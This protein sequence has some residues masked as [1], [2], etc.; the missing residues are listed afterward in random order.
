MA[1]VL[2]ASCLR[3]PRLAQ[4]VSARVM[5]VGVLCILTSLFASEGFA[6]NDPP[7]SPESL[8]L[9]AGDG[10]ISLSWNAPH[11]PGSHTITR[12]E[13]SYVSNAGNQTY[14]STGG[15]DLSY[16]I[17]GL[18]NGYV[19][20]VRVRAVSAAGNGASTTGVT[21]T[22]TI[23]APT[24]LT[25]TAGDGQISLSWTAP[26]VTT[27]VDYQY[28]TSYP[29]GP[30]ASPTRT[31][32]KNTTLTLTGLTNGTT[33]T[34]N[35]RAYGAGGNGRSATVTATP[36]IAAPTGLTATTG[37]T[38]I[39]LN[40]TAVSGVSTITKYQYQKDTDAWADTSANTSHI[41]TGLTNG[42]QYGFK[43]RAVGTGGGGTATASVTG[44]PRLSAPAAPTGL[45]A[46]PG[47]GQITLNWTAPSGPITRY[48]YSQDGGTWTS[49]GGT[50]TTYIVTNLTNGT[51][52]AFRVR[53]V[54]SAGNGAASASVTGTPV[55]TV[56]A[57]G[58]PTGLTAT[59]GNGQITLNWTAPSGPITRYEYTQDDGTT[60]TSTGGTSTTYI[61][62]NLTNG[63]QYTFKVR[64]VNSAGNGA[65]SASVTA[66]P[67]FSA[68]PPPPPPPPA[69]P[70]SL[71]VEMV[72]NADQKTANA[73][74]TW[75]P[76]SD[77]EAEG[78]EYRY[79]F[80]PWTPW[81]STGS[82]DTT[83]T[84]TGLDMGKAY[85]FQIRAFTVNGEGNPDYFYTSPSSTPSKA[86][87]IAPQ[88]TK[89]RIFECPVGWTRGS[90]F[91]NTK[92]ALLYEL[93]L[94]VDRTNSVSIYQLK[95]LAIYVHP[96]EGL[97]T[98]DGWTL[99]VGTLYNNFGKV[100]KLTAENSVIDEHDFAHI[101]NPKDTP[102]PM[103][104]VG[105]IG[106]SLPGFDYR[107]YDA[108][109]LRV[110][111]G[112]SCYKEGGLTWRLWNT[113]DPRVIRVLPLVE[114]EAGLKEMMRNLNWG[115]LFFR[116]QW[117][118]A[119][120]PDLP[121]APAAPTVPRKL[122]GTWA[123]LKKQ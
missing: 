4:R 34:C 59:P 118:A 35:V 15:T 40:W 105:F 67:V 18:S 52:Y 51:Q 39:T 9:T 71:N 114:S 64:A 53:A 61:V 60:W 82:A 12:Y 99:K 11:D 91:G 98:L 97:E 22:P 88:R 2:S 66:T 26:S 122:V 102:I 104:T 111:F 41:V 87:A 96:N 68:P 80:N 119:I 23:A 78:Y 103:G 74:L 101:K 76:P 85:T 72:A 70:V 38:Q 120:M 55:K 13:Y 28:W 31:G 95:S 93:K 113:K 57:P 32:N 27:I 3:G 56:V 109:G 62:T 16:T 48:E 24:G 123:D 107:L 44:T 30:P 79:R 36:T 100:F 73:I 6:Q 19:Y 108:Q 5:F 121:D 42:T 8:T 54:N 49:T 25:A 7:T 1:V 89:P 20:T 77:T 94:N 92:K 45:T 75:N 46:T 47:D 90:V 112:I 117:T 86:D 84:V 29:T 83:Y 43:V 65:A 116:T 81:K 10:Q 110:D 69:D 37:D 14:T 33:Y 63:T 115:S 50:S 17:T 58:A 21:A 106:Q